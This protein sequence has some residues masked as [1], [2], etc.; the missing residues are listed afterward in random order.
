MFLDKTLYSHS[1][2]LRPDVEMGSGKFNAGVSTAMDWY[3]ITG[4]GVEIFLVA[5]WYRYRYALRLD[6]DLTYLHTLYIT[7]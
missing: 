3:H 2:S 7:A 5:L 1:A 4:G 6:A